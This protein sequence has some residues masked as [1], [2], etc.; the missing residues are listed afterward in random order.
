MRMVI[1][2]T[3][4]DMDNHTRRILLETR[5]ILLET[6]WI[7]WILLENCWPSLLVQSGSVR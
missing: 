3:D 1:S 7:L 4:D 5:W 2:S 6:R